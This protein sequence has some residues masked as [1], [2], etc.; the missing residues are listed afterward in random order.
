MTYA[1]SFAKGCGL[2]VLSSAFVILALY[3]LDE[4]SPD[5]LDTPIFITIINCLIIG[6]VL[7]IFSNMKLRYWFPSLPI[8]FLFLIFYYFVDDFMS[9]DFY[10]AIVAFFAALQAIILFISTVSSIAIESSKSGHGKIKTIYSSCF[11]SDSATPQKLLSIPRG[12]VAAIILQAAM[13]ILIQFSTKES[14]E[15]VSLIFIMVSLGLC[16]FF[17]KI[18]IR[19]WFISLPV[20][21]ILSQLCEISDILKYR[22]DIFD[23]AFF[24]FIELSFTLVYFIARFIIK[25]RFP[26]GILKTHYLDPWS[27]D[28]EPRLKS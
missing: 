11:C 12:A 22:M 6:G 14:L 3:Y 18:N 13:F 9:W 20:C 15:P 21:F 4:I 5:L 1:K 17:M 28:N 7:L 19:H 27:F 16:A 8:N 26:Q 2:I 24:Y 23:W 10:L 25:Y